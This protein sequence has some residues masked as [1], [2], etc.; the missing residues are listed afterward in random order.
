M[1]KS[2]LPILIYRHSP[3]WVS[4]A[5]SQM[6]PKSNMTLWKLKDSGVRRMDSRS[7]GF[8][9][10]FKAYFTLNYLLFPLAALFSLFFPIFPS[11]ISF[12]LLFFTLPRCLVSLDDTI[13]LKRRCTPHTLDYL[14]TPQCPPFPHLL[15]WISQL[16]SF[17]RFLSNLAFVMSVTSTFLIGFLASIRSDRILCP[18]HPTLWLPYNS[19]F[20]ILGSQS[21][22]WVR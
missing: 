6:K 5:N 4:W 1:S 22:D 11:T 2:Y 10:E 15:I 16:S 14:A 7:L 21:L 9:A 12:V 3:W 13:C 20:Q 18:R 8:V 17:F 19:P